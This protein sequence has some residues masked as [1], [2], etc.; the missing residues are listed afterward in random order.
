M[1]LYIEKECYMNLYFNTVKH[2]SGQF[3][4][5]G[6]AYYIFMLSIILSL[7]DI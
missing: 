4:P 1:L 3:K 7:L 2:L 5:L 6:F